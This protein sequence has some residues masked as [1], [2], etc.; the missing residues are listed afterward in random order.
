MSCFLDTV[1][2]LSYCTSTRTLYSSGIPS[3]KSTTDQTVTVTPPRLIWHNVRVM[4]HWVSNLTMNTHSGAESEVWTA[5]DICD[6]KSRVSNIHSL[7]NTLNC[8]LSV[9][10]AEKKQYFTAKASRL[11]TYRAGNITQL[12]LYIHTVY[13]SML[14]NSLLRLALDG[15]IS[16]CFLPPQFIKN[17]GS[18]H[19]ISH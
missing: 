11:D 17:K 15:R 7:N 9:A 2:H 18:I 14:A 5:W 6:G 16:M 3:R 19:V 4:F 12:L 1:W 13:L 10:W 8:L